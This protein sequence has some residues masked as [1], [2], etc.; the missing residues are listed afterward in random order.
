[1][2]ASQDIL[3]KDARLPGDSPGDQSIT[4]KPSNTPTSP[5]PPVGDQ[6]SRQGKKKT[7]FVAS[8]KAGTKRRPPLVRR[9]SSQSSS[10]SIT[11][12]T[13]RSPQKS[14]ASSELP[15]SSTSNFPSIDPYEK[16]D[17]RLIP[18]KLYFFVQIACFDFLF[19]SSFSNV[20]Q[21]LVPFPR[22]PSTAKDQ[23][24]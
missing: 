17:E 14:S 22:S 21:I 18:S 15:S 9:K 11:S 6:S 1:M 2:G 16:A 19:H 4:R 24:K 23:K 7:Q 3:Q 12:A 8:T 5:K 10:T 13:V 20:G